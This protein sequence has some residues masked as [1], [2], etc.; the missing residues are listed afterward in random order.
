MMGPIAAAES[1][2]FKAFNFSGRAP[3]SEYWWW[4]LVYAVIIG[5]LAWL[6][7][8]DVIGA[9]PTDQPEIGYS[10]LVFALLCVIPNFAVTVRRL[11]D[12]GRSGFWTFISAVPI[13][14]PFWFLF[15]MCLP[16]E[17]D[18]NIYGPPFRRTGRRS[19]NAKDTGR[20][21]P[22]QGYAI[23]DRLKE[24]PSEEMIAARKQEVRDYYRSRVLQN[25]SKA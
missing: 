25:T 22:M 16:S 15:L 21:D 23:L 19:G 3:R 1:V 4:G 8:S 6:D 7:F 2:V 10:A 24:E 9:P 5:G 17:R 18:D 20:A 13:V 11:H 14:G 12:S